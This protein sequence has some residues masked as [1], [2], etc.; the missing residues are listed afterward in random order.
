[1]LLLAV[2]SLTASGLLLTGVATYL[3]LRWKRMPVLRVLD[4]WAPCGML[5]WA[6]LALG[7]FAEGSDPGVA[8]HAGETG[9]PLYPVALYAFGAALLLTLGVDRWLGRSKRSGETAGMALL[10]A[11]AAQFLLSFLRQ[12]GLAMSAGLDALQ[13]VALGMMVAGAGLLVWSEGHPL[14]RREQGAPG[15]VHNG[16]MDRS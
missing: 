8:R 10:G 13:W 4:A 9:S 11:G 3:W 5:V 1:M 6:F 14:P 2:P 12:P 15:Q 7:H 16:E